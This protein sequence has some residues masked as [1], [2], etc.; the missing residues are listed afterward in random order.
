LGASYRCYQR[1]YEEKTKLANTWEQVNDF[2]K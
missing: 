1:I 2:S